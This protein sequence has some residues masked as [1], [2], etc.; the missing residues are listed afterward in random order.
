VQSLQSTSLRTVDLARCSGYSVQQVR[1]LEHEG[2]IP[3]AP[4]TPASYRQFDD[5]HLHALNAYRALA[6]GLGPVSAKQFLR[7]ALHAPTADTLARFDAAH[8][9]LTTER[10]Q[11]AAA[12]AAASHIAAE[13]I[14]DVNDEDWLSVGELASALGLRTSTLRFWESKDL[15]VPSRTSNRARRYSPEHVR[16]ARIVHQL[17]TIGQPIDGI[18]TLLPELRSGLRHPEMDATFAA[19]EANITNRSLALL[20]AATPLRALITQT[21]V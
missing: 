17:R 15:V 14:T 10:T 4:R 12:R 3:K 18:R 7:E 16:D 8:A 20:D 5:G 19:R 21:L 6:R 13:P 1:K 11:L 2:V 9:Q